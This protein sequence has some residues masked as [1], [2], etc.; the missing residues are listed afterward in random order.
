MSLPTIEIID[1]TNRDGEQTSRVC[2]SKLQKTVLNWL[3]DDM[4]VYQSE[5]GFPLSPH[6]RNYI[7]AN[8]VK[9]GYWAHAEISGTSEVNAIEE[10]GAVYKWEQITINTRYDGA[11]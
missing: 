4:G 1:V 7:N 8:Q 2:L 5:M 11:M 3:L 6:E 9:A 10:D